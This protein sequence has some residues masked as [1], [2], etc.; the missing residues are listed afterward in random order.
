[1]ALILGIETATE[2]CS[3]AIIK[4]EICL[5]EHNNLDGNAHVSQLHAMVQNLMQENGFGLNQL[6]AIAISIG[7]GSYTGLRV[8]VSAAKGF[9]FA[10][11][12]P[13]I[14]ITSLKSLA[15]RFLVQTEKINGLLVPMIDARRMEV[16]SAVYDI[17]LTELEPIHAKILEEDSFADLANTSPLYL[18]GNGASKCIQFLN[19]PNINIIPNFHCGAAGLAS[20]AEQAFQKSDFLNLAYFEPL[21]LKDFIGTTPKNRKQN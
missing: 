7:P 8:G 20:L 15:N 5:A 16:Y 17:N 4:D 2:V 21:Y 10:L 9:A 1:M 13:V 12:I 11:N 14:G 6:N 18:F 3:V 19:H